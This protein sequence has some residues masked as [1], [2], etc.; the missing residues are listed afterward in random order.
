MTRPRRGGWLE[1][2]FALFSKG[3]VIGFSIA[4]PVGPIGLLCI[5]RTLAGGAW[6]GVVTGLGAATADAAYGCVAGLGLTAVSD[7]L[8]GGQAWLG[9]GGGAFLCCL[10]V[11]TFR[12]RPAERP[13]REGR[14]G[15]LGNYLSTLVL[16]LTNPLT[17]LSFAAVFA[18]VGLGAGGGARSTL[19]LVAGVFAGSCAWWLLLS[20]GVSLF[21]TQLG[22]VWLTGINRGAGLLLLASGLYALAAAIGR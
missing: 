19:A 2:V 7:L 3:L 12:A 21:R 13:A 6:S 8:V 17:I 9:I 15:L 22:P 14:A 5:R 16:T 20:G 4:A 11:R 10:G 1:R 18:G